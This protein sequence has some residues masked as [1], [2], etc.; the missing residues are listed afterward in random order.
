[1]AARHEIRHPVAPVRC[2]SADVYANATGR[3]AFHLTLGL[4]TFLTTD[5]GDPGLSNDRTVSTA[6]TCL[7]D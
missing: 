1:M 7:R 6:P 3:G 4:A 2:Q 5:Y